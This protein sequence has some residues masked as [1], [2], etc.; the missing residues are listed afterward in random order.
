MHE[1]SSLSYK[2]KM[3]ARIFFGFSNQV[4]FTNPMELHAAAQ[5]VKNKGNVIPIASNIPESTIRGSKT[6]DVG[7]FGMISP[8]KGI[9][10]F[11]TICKSIKIPHQAYLMGKIP[12]YFKD[13]GQKIVKA[14]EEADIEVILDK[15]P[16]DVADLLAALKF[17]VLPFPD[18]LTPRRGS[19][20]AAMLN[21][22]QVVSY[23]SPEFFNLF[24]EFAVLCGDLEDMKL[25]VN[26]LLAD[27]ASHDKIR[28]ANKYAVELSWPYVA[29]RYIEI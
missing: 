11:L 3:A 7:Y 27:G 28:K 18:G 2:A 23:Q 4:V 22:A 5:F 29:R 10:D 12:H 26:T 17:A 13:Y 19:A 21:S 15:S 24:D 1:F 9:E 20:L 8:G 25:K 6:Y 14:C 16:D